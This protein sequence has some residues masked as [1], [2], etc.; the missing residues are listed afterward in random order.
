MIDAHHHL[1]RYSAAEY[2]W[3]PPETA[4]AQD[5]LLRELEAASSVAGV[6]GTVVVQARQVL[7]ESDELLAL[8]DESALIRGVVGWVPLIDPA[9]ESEI[10]RLSQRPK[11]KAVRHVLQGE[12]DEYFLGDDF[13]RGLA[14]LPAYGMRYDLLVFQRQ[15]PLAIRL[16]DRQMPLSFIVDH[17]AKPEIR[18]GQINPLWKSNMAALAK[19]ENVTGVKFSGIVTEVLDAEIDEPTLHAY[20]EET[21]ALF[22]AERVMFGTDWPVCLL[23]IGSYQAWAAMVGRFVA[24]LTISEQEKI[25]GKNCERIY[26]L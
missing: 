20:F 13:H 17:I 10:A 11:F 21:L 15:L 25:L 19:R 12:P 2:G 9:V 14:L 18:N 26:G 6:T 3:I 8:A 24:T 5:Q 4:L 23:R 16:I 1:W 22:G 7:E